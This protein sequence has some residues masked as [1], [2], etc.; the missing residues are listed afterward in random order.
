MLLTFTISIFCICYFILFILTLKKAIQH[1][2]FYMYIIAFLALGLSYDALIIALGGILK[3]DTIKTQTFQTISLIR[4]IL[5]GI[6]IPFHFVICE[7]VLK[8]KKKIWFPIIL[9]ITIIV[10]IIGFI[11]GIYTQ[12]ELAFAYNIYRYASSSSNPR[13]VIILFLFITIFPMIPLLITG[14]IV[15]RKRKNPH[16]FLSAFFMFAFA[17]IA[18][19]LRSLKEIKFFISMIGELLMCVFFYIYINKDIKEQE[20]KR[21]LL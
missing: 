3:L 17:W 2:K 9:C 10:A 1:K 20:S 5:H 7:E 16:I 21:I 11:Q 19:A 15:Y 18:E 8:P 12:L 14:F 4:Y 6:I 13:W